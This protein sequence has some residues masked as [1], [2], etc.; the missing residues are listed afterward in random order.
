M[1]ARLARAAGYR[2]WDE[3]W[4]SLFEHGAIGM[5]SE[6]WRRQ[7]ATFCAAARASGGAA[8][9]TTLARERHM[10]QTIRR[11]LAARGLA[12]D[13]AMVVCGG[14]HL[15]LDRQDL[16]E[17]PPSPPGT[18][19]HA[20]VPYSHTRIWERTG[21]AAGNRAPR[22]YERL[23]AAIRA[24]DP[25]TA[26]AEQAI[27]ILHAARRKGEALATFRDKG[28]LWVKP[29]KK[30]KVKLGD[31]LTVVGPPSPGTTQREVYGTGAVMGV[32]AHDDR[33]FDFTFHLLQKIRK[34]RQRILRRF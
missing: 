32:P 33:D 24:G 11:E 22:W 8:D 29:S 17:P 25:S 6:D 4:D 9:A 23:H 2:R 34:C 20:L 31:E 5:D 10:W 1:K 12:P 27:D 14:F 16:A 15:F 26:L 3:A 30:T 7:L 13:A 28:D 19:H 21:Y 18:V